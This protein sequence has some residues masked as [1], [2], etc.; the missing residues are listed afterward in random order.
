MIND[1]IDN[2]NKINSLRQ[3][4]AIDLDTELEEAAE[5]WRKI[6]REH[7]E[8]FNKTL[9]NVVIGGKHR[10][11]RMANDSTTGGRIAYEFIQQ[12]DLMGVYQDT[13]IQ[14]GVNKKDEPIYSDYITAWAKHSRSQVY[15]KGVIFMP[16]DRVPA[17]YFNTWR[18]FAVEPVESPDDVILIK[19]H[20]EEVICAGK[21]E[22]IDYV[23]NWIAFSVQYPAIPVGT[24]LVC[25]G[26]KGTG[27]G[28]LFRFLRDLWGQHGKHITSCEHLTGKFNAH[29]SDVCL[30]FVDEA[31]F[32]NDKKHEGVLKG[33][34]TEPTLMIERKGVDAVECKNYLKIVMATNS[35][36]AIPASKDERRYMVLD[37]TNDYVGNSDYF[38]SL[39]AETN[40]D[41]TQAAFLYEMLHRDISGF[42]PSRVPDTYGL[43]AQREHSLGSL[44]KWWMECITRGCVTYSGD[45]EPLWDAE[46]NAKELRESYL[47]FCQENKVSGYDIATYNAL[48]RYLRTLAVKKTRSNGYTRYQMGG[49]DEAMQRFSEMEKVNFDLD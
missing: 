28:T 6:W 14:T 26:D 17:G 4:V 38:S 9:S 12:K 3:A 49:L 27:K 25:R 16:G 10:I 18:G 33:L 23:Y 24:A 19:H 30:L 42:R 7:T 47:V 37:A 45:F 5:P 22:V 34:I 2:V 31:F 48:G 43:R 36:W 1:N 35:D 46:F 11:M 20:I 32:S 8:L 41:K 29:L 13:L 39:I 15:R 40:S 21:Q 44:Q